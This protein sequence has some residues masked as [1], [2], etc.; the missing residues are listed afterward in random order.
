[1][2]AVLCLTLAGL[3]GQ[4]SKYFLGHAR[5]GGF[6]Y[7]FGLDEEGNVPTWYSSMTLFVCAVLLLVNGILAKK[8]GL[9]YQGHWL[10][11]S[12]VFLY[13]SIDEFCTIHEKFIKSLRIF[14]HATEYFYS[15]WVI[16]ALILVPAFGLLYVKFLKHLPKRVR[17]EFILAG[18]IYVGGAL[19]MELI[20]GHY[21]YH[22]GSENF[23]YALFVVLE[24]FMEMTGVVI[25]IHALLS[26][27]E[28]VTGP[29]GLLL[30]I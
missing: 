3:A 19:G 5:L 30:K 9:G 28:A 16:P 24:E 15:S 23:Y 11:L 25:F 26:H 20:E 27:L 10:L 13:L 4:F 7:M 6:V 12:A 8:N 29:D 2:G 18:I 17:L 21:D 22:F 1:M 14:F